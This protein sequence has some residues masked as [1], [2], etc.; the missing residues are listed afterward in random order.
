[1]RGGAANWLS[2]HGLV[3]ACN[4][5]AAGPS[6]LAAKDVISGPPPPR[7]SAGI[8]DALRNDRVGRRVRGEVL[9][10]ASGIGPN[11]SVG[12]G[13]AWRLWGF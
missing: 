1:V 7:G 5:A 9:P 4:L 2:G 10:F 11:R 6:R 8:Q 3:C 12:Q 13:G